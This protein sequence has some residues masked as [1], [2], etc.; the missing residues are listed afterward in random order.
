MASYCEAGGRGG[1]GDGRRRACD[2]R[3]PLGAGDTRVFFVKAHFTKAA[4]ACWLVYV[5]V[6]VVGGGGAAESEESNHP[7]G[8]KQNP[9]KSSVGT[10]REN[11]AVCSAVPV[12]YLPA[13][14]RP[15]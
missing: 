2:A 6:V 12:R 13:M 15:V 11:P 9:Q 5:G 3:V 7:T 4:R 8:T 10:P 1:R 14:K